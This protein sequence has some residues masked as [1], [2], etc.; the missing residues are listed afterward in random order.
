[1]VESSRHPS[2]HSLKPIPTTYQWDRKCIHWRIHGEIRNV[3]VMLTVLGW[4]E[5]VVVGHR[6]IE[7]RSEDLPCRRTRSSKQYTVGMGKLA[8]GKKCI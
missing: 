7:W 8:T 4:S 2:D 3:T 5:C 1:M 6:I